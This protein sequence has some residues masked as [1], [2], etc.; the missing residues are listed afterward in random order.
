VPK[1]GLRAGGLVVIAIG[2]AHFFLP[3]FGYD[4][5][6]PAAMDPGSGAHFFYL[7]TYAIGGFL[8]AFGIISLYTSKLA[9]TRTAA[10]FAGLMA[11]MWGWRTALEIIYPVE[12]R[13]FILDRPTLVLL[14][15]L[16][17]L[18]IVYAC[19]ALGLGL[20]RRRPH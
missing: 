3:T 6:I 18:T 4:P 20:A 8:I 15:A 7:G 17:A 2:L 13:L 12:L 1:W 11:L 14:P 10:L 9:D 19:S 5:A 16:A